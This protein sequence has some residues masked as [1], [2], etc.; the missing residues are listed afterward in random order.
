MTLKF[1][2]QTAASVK[3]MEDAFPTVL[4]VLGTQLLEECR[5]DWETVVITIEAEPQF[6]AWKVRLTCR[7]GTRDCEARGA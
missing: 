6:N 3:V 4:K 2:A 1:T 5:P 7:G